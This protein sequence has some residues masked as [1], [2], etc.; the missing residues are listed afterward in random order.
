[1]L[2][3]IAPVTLACW[4]NIRAPPWAALASIASGFL[5]VVV[6]VVE[7]I[8]RP[9]RALLEA[10][11]GIPIAILVLLT[12]TTMLLLGALIQKTRSIALQPLGFQ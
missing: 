6:A 12:S 1:M 2:L 4:L 3:A 9:T 11:L 7:N 10:P 8:D 5:V